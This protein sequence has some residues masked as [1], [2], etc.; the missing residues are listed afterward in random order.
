[1][2]LICVCVVENVKIESDKSE[3][4]KRLKQFARYYNR[5]I[6]FNI[7]WSEPFVSCLQADSF[8]VNILD[9]PDS[10]NCELFLQPDGWFCNGRIDKTP[11][12]VRMK[13][14]EEICASFVNKK[15]SVMLYLSQSGTHPNDFERVT[16]R[17]NDLVE[18]LTKTV[19]VNG[20][21]DGVQIIVKTGDGLRD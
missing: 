4:I 6:K 9:A 15:R 3:Y 18:Y 17:I 12:K 16:L 14:L 21:K 10:D 2:S 20:I 13:F 1:M 7:D 5:G 19:G 8:V 11:F